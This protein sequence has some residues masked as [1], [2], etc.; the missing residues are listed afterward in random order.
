MKVADDEFLK[1]LRKTCDE[2]GLLLYFDEI[3]CGMGRTG[4]LFAHEWSGVT[5]DVMCIAKALGN[6]F[7]LGLVWPQ[8]KRLKAW[9]PAR[10]AQPTAE[11]RWLQPLVMPFWTL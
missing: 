4:K 8:P 2:F 6:G 5:P 7:R 11:I 9:A 1:A 10:M 3:Q